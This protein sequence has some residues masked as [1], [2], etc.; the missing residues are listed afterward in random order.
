MI[1]CNIL[2]GLPGSG[3]S[4]WANKQ[5]DFEIVSRDAFVDA[6]ANENGITYTEAFE[7]INQPLVNELF[8]ARLTELVK[9]K[10]NIIIDRTNLSVKSRKDIFKR[11]FPKDYEFHATVFVIPENELNRRL[12]AREASTGK[13]IP[14]DVI[15]KMAAKYES[16]TKQEGFNK[17]KYIK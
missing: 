11:W 15:K 6:Y 2:V 7:L 14:P 4:T 1:I 8:Y 13:H 10:K 16:P 12:T 5:K 9:A 17:I 3:K